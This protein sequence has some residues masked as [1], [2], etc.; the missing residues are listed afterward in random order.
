M[1]MYNKLIRDN[2]DTIINND[3]NNELAVTRILSYKEYNIELLKKLEEEINEL[4][5]AI[6]S[7]ITK[8]IIEESADVIEVIRAING[9]NLE[10][11]MEKLEDKRIKKVASVKENT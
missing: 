7:G 6:S 3:G 4:K 1:T 2:I 8:D 10:L 9:D 11:V 5:T